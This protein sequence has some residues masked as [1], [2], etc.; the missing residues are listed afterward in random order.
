VISDPRPGIA[1]NDWRSRSC[2]RS[3]QF[4]HSP[5]RRAH[6]FFLPRA[7]PR[8]RTNGAERNGSRK[9]KDRAPEPQ[10]RGAEWLRLVICSCEIFEDS[11]RT[12]GPGANPKGASLS[13]SEARIPLGSYEVY[14]LPRT[15]GG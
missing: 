14:I 10:R 2:E 13:Y 3:E 12:R 5:A 1:Y 9:G 6:L 15:S 8:E 4:V 11:S 7:R